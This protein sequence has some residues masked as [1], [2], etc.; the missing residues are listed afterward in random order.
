MTTQEKLERIRNRSTQYELV[1]I[2]ENHKTYLAGYCHKS[3]MAI[4]KML[5][6]NGEK[7]TVRI[8]P[9][10]LITFARNGQSAQVGRFLV[11]FTGRTQREAIISGE[12]P[13]F[14]EITECQ[15]VV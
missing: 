12:F 9:K 1:A 4:L 10:D 11:R 8:N 13:W 3:K 5:Q 7:W 6:K 15:P 2:D 14:E